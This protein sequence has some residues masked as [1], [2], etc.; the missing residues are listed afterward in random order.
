MADFSN[1]FS[2]TSQYEGGYKLDSNDLGGLE[3]YCGITRKNFPDWP[4]WA[5][6]DSHKPLSNGDIIP[7]DGLYSLVKQFYYKNFWG[8]CN[9]DLCDSQRVSNVVY[10]WY[11][12]SRANAIKEIQKV[13]GINVD[14]GCG[15]LTIAAI[16]SRNEDVLLP[17]L[18]AARICY[19]KEIVAK[20]PSQKE[21]LNG[22]LKRANGFA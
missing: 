9:L 21:Y 7:D 5:I 2:I 17:E 8:R 6:V 13:L 19:Y 3:T 18:I 1:A 16:N 14:G 4:G 22:W 11:V 15:T 10:D 20:N 12:H